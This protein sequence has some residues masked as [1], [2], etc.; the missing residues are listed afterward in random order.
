MNAAAFWILW[1]ID[2]LITILAIVGAA[3]RESWGAHSPFTSLHF[4]VIV[5]GIVAMGASLALRYIWKLPQVSL[6]V[7]AI[8][9]LMGFAY[10]WVDSRGE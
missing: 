5:V 7:V 8:P 4:W 10:Y 9:L 6:I 2:L 1:S 3:A